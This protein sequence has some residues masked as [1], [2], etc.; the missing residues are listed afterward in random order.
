M[1]HETALSQILS[2]RLGIP[3]ASIRYGQ[4][5]TALTKVGGGHG[6]SR[7]IELG[8]NAVMKAADTVEDKA[9]ALAAH[10]LNARTED[11]AFSDG[12]VRDTATGRSVTIAELIKAAADP[13]RLPAAMSVAADANALDTTEVY[14]RQ[15]ITVPNGCH[16]AEVEIDPETGFV[17]VKGFWAVDDFGRIVNPMLADGQVMGG[18]AQ[19]L[20][21]AL[22]EEVVYD[23][24]SGQLLTAS[25][26]D[27]TMPRADDM[28]PLD[29]AYYE[30]APT[31]HNPIG[32]KGAG[33]AGCC[34]APPAI[35]NA[36]IDALA[37]WGVT[38]IDMPVTPEKVWRAINGR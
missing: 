24:D 26:M 34:G 31:K 16:A 32:S 18:I 10:M 8:G 4:A 29:V 27:Y 2:A 5:D 13:A 36:V 19:G 21:Q 3:M 15:Q 28:P 30:D 38:H 25:F 20:G 22:L 6:G 37:E 14:E 35:V 7:G 9:K 12:V 33:E 1:G 11:M 23:N 17:A